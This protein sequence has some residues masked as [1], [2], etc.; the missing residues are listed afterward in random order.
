MKRR[1]SELVDDGLVRSP[2]QRVFERRSRDRLTVLAYHAVEDGR[3]F[4]EKL[5]FLLA[6]GT[7]VS[8]QQLLGAIRGNAPL[9]P[10]PFHVTFDDGDPTV[11]ESGLPALE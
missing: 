9:P 11:L 3:R 5:D 1:L 2:A 4:G 6:K 8:I 7:P 10:R